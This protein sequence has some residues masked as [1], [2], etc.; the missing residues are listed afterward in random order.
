MVS[1]GR[2]VT[3]AN[4]VGV[5]QACLAGKEVLTASAASAGLRPGAQ[6]T[7]AA[8]GSKGTKRSRSKFAVRY[9]VRGYENP[10]G[11]ISMRGPAHLVNNDT[12]PHEIRP[13]RV[14][15]LTIPYGTGLAAVVHHPGTKGKKFF[16]HAEPVIVKQSERIIE[17]AVHS[18]LARVFTGR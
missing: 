16:E 11:I 18:H 9:Q 2:A 3:R 14:K 17:S 15:A 4:R 8:S 6:L 1:G 13:R 5:E 12:R 7:G 10:V